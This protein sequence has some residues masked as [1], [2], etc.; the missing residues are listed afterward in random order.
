MMKAAALAAALIAS[1]PPSGAT[2][3]SKRTIAVAAAANLKLAIEDLEKGFEAENP[4]TEVTVTLG[5]SGSFFAQLQNGAPFDV[6][7]SADTEYPRKVIEAGLAR[8]EDETVYAVGK[9]VVWAP[10][11]AK[12]HL[13]RMG[14][15]AV[16][17]P[18]VK[19]LAIAN[20]AVAPYGRAAVAALRAAGVYEAV[21]DRLVLG[22]NVAQA[23]Q[24]AQS[25]AAEAALIPLSLTFSPEL[26]E[27]K[28]LVVPAD[29]YPAQAQSAVVL[30]RAREPELARAFVR[31]VTG[32]E[33]REILLQSGYALP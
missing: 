9:L 11:S 8:K 2:A 4:G 16:A 22:Q 32:P 33:G 31:Y 23:A 20:P 25:G 14:V 13:K 18:A 10:R 3:S 6:F 1:S 29:S 30:G 5:A 26:K 28:I 17:D 12:V 27:G 19:K 24:F 21:K 15:A 7:F